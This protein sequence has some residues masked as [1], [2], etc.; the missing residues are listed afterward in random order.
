MVCKLPVYIPAKVTFSAERTGDDGWR[1]AVRD[2]GS[3][4][5]HLA[6]TIAHR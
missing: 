2:A 1:F 5:P 6:G 3:G 4:R